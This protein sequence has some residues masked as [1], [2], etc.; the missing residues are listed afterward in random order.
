M[1]RPFADVNI[2]THAWRVTTSSGRGPPRH[3]LKAIPHCYRS[4]NGL[5]NWDK[6][7]R[8][9]PARVGATGLGDHERARGRL[10]AVSPRRYLRPLRSLAVA[11]V[12]VRRDGRSAAG[13][14]SIRFRRSL[15]RSWVHFPGMRKPWFNREYLVTWSILCMSPSMSRNRRKRMD[16]Y[17]P[18]ITR[19]RLTPEASCAGLRTRFSAIPT[20]RRTIL[21]GTGSPR[22]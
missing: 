18:P 2:T 5:L 22:S 13:V 10:A 7:D 20:A 1:G 16:R 11:Q 19:G 17:R 6:D 9:G 8:E 14:A 12:D 21:S 3:P 15:P 4:S